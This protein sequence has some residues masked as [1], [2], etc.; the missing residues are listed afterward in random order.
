MPPVPVVVLL[1]TMRSLAGIMQPL[2][3]AQTPGHPQAQAYQPALEH[4]DHAIVGAGR[5]FDLGQRKILPSPGSQVLQGRVLRGETAQQRWHP[6]R[7]PQLHHLQQTQGTGDPCV[8]APASTSGAAAPA[9]LKQPRSSE[10]DRGEELE[11]PSVVSLSGPFCFSKSRTLQ[12]AQNAASL[13]GVQHVSDAEQSLVCLAEGPQTKA[14]ETSA[15]NANSLESSQ[16][17]HS[18]RQAEPHVSI[19][20]CGSSSTSLSQ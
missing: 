1:R 18:S 19:R 9:R 14:C 13:S 4:R 6:R 7:V 5:L 15:R 10:S 17:R 3:H 12:K 2:P 11:C 16:K 20:L 8:E